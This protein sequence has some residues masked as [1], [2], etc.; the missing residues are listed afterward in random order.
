MSGSLSEPLRVAAGALVGASL[1]VAPVQLAAQL[2]AP[3]AVTLTSSGGVSKGAYQAGLDWAVVQTLRHRRS[4]GA[5]SSR[6]VIRAIT[7]AS[8]GNI[9]ALANA[10]LWCTRWRSRD[11]ESPARSL[12]W[13]LWVN[14]GFPQLMPESESPEEPGLLQRGFFLKHLAP[15][16]EQHLQERHAQPGCS[17]PVGVALTRVQPEVVRSSN[18]LQTRVQRFASVFAVSAS[19]SNRIGLQA[20]VARRG[21]SSA[22][23]GLPRSLGAL[24]IAPALKD[25]H[26]DRTERLR[27]IFE[28][29]IAS[30]S[31]PIAFAPRPIAYI[32]EGLAAHERPGDVERAEFADGGIFDNNP[33]ALAQRMVEL[34]D[35]AGART[36]N[37]VVAVL[38][39]PYNLRGDLASKRTSNG[40]QRP[41]HGLGGAA[42]LLMG[43]FV[44]AQ[45]YELQSYQRLN[46]RDEE[47]D[48]S[49]RGRI[50][51]ASA[52]RSMPIVG[53]Q[54]QSFA[55]FTGRLFREHDFY[56]GIYDGLHHTV[57]TFLCADAATAPPDSARSRDAC[58]RR[59]LNDL[60]HDN[61][62]HLDSTA[63]QVVSWYLQGAYPSDES[64]T[65][66]PLLSMHAAVFRAMRAVGPRPE[67]G[68]C[69]KGSLLTRRLCEGGGRWL[70]DALRNDRSFMQLARRACE[71]CAQAANRRFRQAGECTVDPELYGYLRD[72]ESYLNRLADSMLIRLVRIEEEQPARIPRTDDAQGTAELLAMWF[73]SSNHRDRRG[74]AI[75][76]GSWRWDTSRP[77]AKIMSLVA[78]LLPNSVH[79]GRGERI[80]LPP[81]SLLPNTQW[82]NPVFAWRPL[83]WQNAYIHVGM[84]YEYTRAR[85][86]VGQ[87]WDARDEH[88][89]G[90][91]FTSHRWHLPY[92]SSTSLQLL[93]G[94]ALLAREER[95]T[96]A[97]IIELSTRLGADKLLVGV[98]AMPSRG[99]QAVI[100]VTDLGGMLY[101][102]VR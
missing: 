41:R 14:T 60:I 89:T 3:A 54:L 49:A 74:F 1:F 79:F 101:W 98:R 66:A 37:R 40:T 59:T 85:H 48:S 67:K 8:A 93:R 9:N 80:A 69:E 51:V 95:T 90:V 15:K 78:P 28:I 75:N 44:S 55:G 4:L 86:P 20:F 18:G 96:P 2:R 6:H 87:I 84:T 7:G 31:Y 99:W 61:P 56:A 73:R 19:D 91:T 39:N 5:D 63:R 83:V 50:E 26:A 57:V 97:P 77:K 35:T 71:D 23:P 29:V 53:E 46:A 72:P 12:H 13:A 47:N 36:L 10:L 58:V 81:G 27:Q 70:I 38:A 11:A 16:V 43:A 64:V 92:T 22:E 42:Q 100:G 52:S 76:P 82:A 62:L 88:R 68:E 102:W 65:A 25:P 45:D 24:A 34:T 21:A 94:T 17:V 32:P 33:V 30:S